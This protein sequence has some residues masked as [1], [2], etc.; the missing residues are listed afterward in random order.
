VKKKKMSSFFCVNMA[1]EVSSLVRL[2]ST[3][4]WFYRERISR[5]EH[6]FAS[7]KW[8]GKAPG[9]EGK[10]VFSSGFRLFLEKILRKIASKGSQNIMMII[11]V[12]WCFMR[13]SK[14]SFWCLERDF[15][16]FSCLFKIMIFFFFSFSLNWNLRALQF[17]SI[18]AK[19]S[20]Y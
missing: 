20:F 16:C 7:A 4:W 9:L 10:L 18:G 2:L 13:S 12:F 3:L 17:I 14:Q 5:I 6:R 11:L 15:I 8:M 19:I 1:A